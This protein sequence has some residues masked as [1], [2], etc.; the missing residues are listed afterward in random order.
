MYN[1]ITMSIH[2]VFVYLSISP[3]Y[4]F[5]VHKIK[6]FT[7][8]YYSIFNTEIIPG[9][10]QTRIV[11]ERMNLQI[12]LLCKLMTNIPLN[13]SEFNH[14]SISRYFGCFQLFTTID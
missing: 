2:I 5:K 1:T 4:E 3:C 6:D 14:S 8:L 11:V 9:A 13:M 7:L 10:E 12:L